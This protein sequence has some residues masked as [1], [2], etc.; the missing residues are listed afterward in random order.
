MYTINLINKKKKAIYTTEKHLL[1]ALIEQKIFVDNPCSGRGLCGK[2]KIRIIEGEVSSLTETEL[3]FLSGKEIDS[4]I[5]LSCQLTPKSDLIIEVLQ[6]E[7]KVRAVTRGYLPNFTKSTTVQKILIELKK[8]KI[9]DKT[10]YEEVFMSLAGATIK[11]LQLIKKL[12][13]IAGKYTAIIYN[14][15]LL[16]IEAGDTR[17]Q[18]YGMAIDIGTTTVVIALV[19]L[20]SGEEI[21]IES[22]I[23]AQN[24]FGLDVLT[25]ITYVHEFGLE[26]I[27]KLQDAIVLSLNS[28][29]DDLCERNFIAKERVYEITVAANTTMLHMLLGVNPI[30]I[31]QAPFTPTFL[32]SKSIFAYEIGLKISQETKL[33]LLPCVSAYIGADIIAGVYVAELVKKAGNVLFIDIGTNGEIV[34]SSKGHITACSCAAGPALEGMN[35][36]N[37]MRASN[38][39]IEDL[40][41]TSA[42]INLIVIGGEK[43]EGLCGS[44]ILA[45]IRE[46]VNNGFLKRN[47]ALKKN[48]DFAEDDYRKR[49]FKND[50]RKKAV[51]LIENPKEIL[52]TQGDIRQVQLA[53]GAILSGFYALLQQA[54]IEMDNLDQI[55]VAGGFGA[56]LPTTS[57]I[58]AGILPKIVEEKVSYIGNSAKTGAYI[59]LLSKK[60]R[61]EMEDLS[62]EIDY[63]ELGTLPGYNNLFMDCL[64][65]PVE[66]FD[67]RI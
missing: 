38:G 31:G 45:T 26:A 18:L 21:D 66:E 23:N 49:M 11:D 7:K 40:S 37:G 27:V 41:I 5:R 32:K 34:L 59:A 8:P 30:S 48:T 36:S 13:T 60:A 63:I 54:G 33:Y 61:K 6:S 35:I 39:A 65:F 67:D 53:K 2:C 16:K 55:I 15:E 14:G 10:S 43:P 42:G 17:Q 22:T 46:L 62:R 57:L 4:G 44:G 24:I 64:D 56:H 29:I 28:M 12:P 1:T 50:G 58:G 9:E 52:I 19:D 47:G 25:R 20:N 3:K 51:V